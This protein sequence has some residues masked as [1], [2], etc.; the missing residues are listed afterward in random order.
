MA[1]AEEPGGLRAAMPIPN[2][3]PVEEENQAFSCAY[4]G[5]RRDGSEPARGRWSAGPSIDGQGGFS[6]GVMEP[7]G[8][9]ADLRAAAE[10][11]GLWR[12]QRD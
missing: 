3:F 7:A 10:N 6:D 2:S 9:G 1:A 8:R 4:L 5:F 12:A 11:S